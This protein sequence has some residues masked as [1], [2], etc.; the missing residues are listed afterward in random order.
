MG[1]MQVQ[2]SSLSHVAFEG[3]GLATLE[4]ALG[5][6]GRRLADSVD[7]TRSLG[8][9]A[10]KRIGA[11]KHFG[12]FDSARALVIEQA[13]TGIALLRD[14]AS[15]TGISP[16]VAE[17]LDALSYTFER[18][19]SMVR[20]EPSAA[21]PRYLRRA[22]GETIAGWG[23]TV[24]REIVAL[25]RVQQG[26]D[27]PTLGGRLNTIGIDAPHHIAALGEDAVRMW[28]LA[29]HHEDQ[30]AMTI[31]G[32]PKRS[33]SNAH[34]GR[35]TIPT[36]EAPLVASLI[37][38]RGAMER[39]ARALADETI[40]LAKSSSTNVIDTT[41]LDTIG[42]HHARFGEQ[43][44]SLQRAVDIVSE[45]MVDAPGQFAGAD[46][47]HAIYVKMIG[48]ALPDAPN[49]GFISEHQERM[50][51]HLKAP[52]PRTEIR[53]TAGALS[54][55]REVNAE[56]AIGDGSRIRELREV[57]ESLVAQATRQMNP[58]TA[59][60]PRPSVANAEA[61]AALTAAAREL[62]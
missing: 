12:A 47:T 43:T 15:R 25:G 36:E 23:S 42:L 38:L 18:L 56:L 51:L 10:G 8:K 53:P 22:M 27:A 31:L 29:T 55:A 52:N 16:A 54:Y 28:A 33:L 11:Q 45:R 61:A 4:T 14:P 30:V 37:S 21:L 50:L 62:S 41:G 58:H 3:A 32:V 34:F 48:R 26:M 40:A 2:V 35:S 57:L 24:E 59:N 19:N 1:F 20:T 9:L 39:E 49:A 7:A 60:P 46:G 17:R 44:D 6:V 13:M 5:A